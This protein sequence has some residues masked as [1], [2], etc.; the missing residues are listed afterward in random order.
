MPETITIREVLHG[1]TPGQL[2]TVGLMQVIPLVSEL[3]DERFAPADQV[4]VSTRSYGE[5]TFRNPTE[6]LLIVPSH[7]GYVVSQAAQDHAM[8]TAAM[9]KSKETQRFGNAY[10]IQQSQ[11]GLINAGVHDLL[12]LPYALREAALFE[13]RKGGGYDSMWRHITWFSIEYG[14]RVSSGNL[15]QFLKHFKDELDQFVAEFEIA[16]SNQTGAIVLIAGDVVGIE[17]SPSPE[18]FRS[19]WEALIRECYGS[20][21][22]QVQKQLKDRVPRTRVP[23]KID[24]VETIDQLLGALDDAEKREREQVANRIRDLL[25]DPFERTAEDQYNDLVL[26]TVKHDQFCGQIIRDGRKVPYASLFTTKDWAKHKEWN[27]APAF[28]I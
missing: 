13:R 5:L 2:Q 21:A 16:D 22:I 12:I 25:D 24:E 7:A 26:E 14:L 20:F 19:I 9:V 23:L 11:G 3:T 10:C 8:S 15:V 4:E 6:K 1:T 17:R 18:Y 28:E 27:A